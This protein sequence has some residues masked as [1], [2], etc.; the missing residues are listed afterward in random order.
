LI[1]VQECH[2]SIVT[3]I[4]GSVSFVFNKTAFCSWRCVVPPSPGKARLEWYRRIV[5]AVASDCYEPVVSRFSSRNLLCTKLFSCQDMSLEEPG[6][7]EG[8][9]DLT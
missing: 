8:H 1:G 7:E 2:L 3:E 6:A 5:F 4:L 9:K